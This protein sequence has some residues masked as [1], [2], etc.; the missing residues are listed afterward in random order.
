M[1]HVI[2][3]LVFLFNFLDGLAT[4]YLTWYSAYEVT[5]VNPLMQN[6]MDRTGDWWLLLKILFGLIILFLIARF[7]KK[8]RLVKMASVLVLLIYVAVVGYQITWILK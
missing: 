5:E 8:Y 2:G 1:G 6:L 4:Y 3:L 7:W